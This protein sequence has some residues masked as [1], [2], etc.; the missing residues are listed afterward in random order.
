MS[1]TQMEVEIFR[2]RGASINNT[3]SK[4]IF[5]STVKAKYI[6]DLSFAI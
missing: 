2:T 1:E 4:Y 3:M 5:T 6:H